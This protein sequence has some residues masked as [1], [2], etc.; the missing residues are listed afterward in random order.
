MN[1]CERETSFAIPVESNSGV[2]EAANSLNAVSA[3]LWDLKHF[4]RK[5]WSRCLKSGNRW[6]R[7]KLQSLCPALVNRNGSNLLYDN[8]RQHV[9]RI[10]LL[11]STSP[12][13][14][15][16]SLARR[17]LLFQAP[18]QLL[19]WEMLHIPERYWNSIHQD[20]GLQ[21]SRILFNT[22]N[23]ICFSLTRL[24]WTLFWLIKF[25]LSWDT[26]IWI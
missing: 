15:A 10:E 9:E 26:C 4:L 14:L 8:A 24:Q 12:T 2:L 6:A 22:N 11:N 20:C 21:E 23:K 19:V 7:E 3:S 18:R 1:F 17:L 5:K 25:C 13:I 16:R